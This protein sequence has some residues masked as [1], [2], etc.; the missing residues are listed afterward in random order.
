MMLKNQ[1]VKEPYTDVFEKGKGK[2]ILDNKGKFIFQIY[3]DKKE[4]NLYIMLRKK[5][6]PVILV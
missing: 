2:L 4:L 3:V 5:I 6:L 1:R